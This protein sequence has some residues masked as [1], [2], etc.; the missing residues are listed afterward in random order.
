[1]EESDY[2]Y[3]Q[4]YKYFVIGGKSTPPNEM[5]PNYILKVIE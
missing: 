3:L 4:D 2:G 1:M 5:I